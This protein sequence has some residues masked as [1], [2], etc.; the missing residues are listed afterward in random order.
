SYPAGED[1]PLAHPPQPHA[2]HADSD[3]T[4][5]PPVQRLASGAATIDQ[6]P[7]TAIPLGDIAAVAAE[8]AR[9][10]QTEVPIPRPAP[11]RP[12]A[13]AGPVTQR[14]VPALPSHHR[15]SHHKP[16]LGAP[17]RSASGGARGTSQRPTAVD[18]AAPA[19]ETSRPT[20]RAESSPAMRADRSAQA[21]PPNPPA[22]P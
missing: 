4:D 18:R 13:P 12:A 22:T 2:G 10:G 15:P 17:L 20:Q 11:R 6:A 16:G 21:A 7:V 3:G 5:G 9:T 8:A 14:S 1:L 19:A